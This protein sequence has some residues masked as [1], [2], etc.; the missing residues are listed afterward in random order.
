MAIECYYGLCPHHGN[1]EA[2]PNEGPFCFQKECIANPEKLPL[3]EVYRIIQLADREV[4]PSWWCTLN[5]FEWPAELVQLK[6]KL[7]P[8]H[9][10][11]LISTKIGLKA[12]LREWNTGSMN[13]DQFEEWWACST[14]E[15]KL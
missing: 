15:G 5:S 6:D 4:L 1:N 7:E 9:I 11:G 8:I 2:P 14:K 12:C 10:M 3:Y 13:D